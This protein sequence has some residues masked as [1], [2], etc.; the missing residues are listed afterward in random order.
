MPYIFLVARDTAVDK[1]DVAPVLM[2]FIYISVVLCRVE[3]VHMV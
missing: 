2:L 3:T 1:L